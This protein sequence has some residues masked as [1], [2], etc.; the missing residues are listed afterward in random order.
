MLYIQLLER[1]SIVAMTAYVFSRTTMF[2]NFYHDKLSHYNKVIMILFFAALSILGDYLGIDVGNR[3]LA[4]TRPIGAIVGGYLGGPLVGVIIGTIAG[5]HRYTLGGFTAL[6]CAVATVFEGLIGGIVGKY[7]KRAKQSFLPPML[8]G[9]AAEVC[10]MAIILLISRPLMDAIYLEKL[11]FLPMVIINTIGVVLFISMINSIKNEYDK[12]F[13]TESQKA[14]IIAQKTISYLKKG[15]NKNTAESIV[16]IIYEVSGID[17][18]C[19][20]DRHE[21][22]AYFGEKVDESNLNRAINEYIENSDCTVINNVNVVSDKNP[23]IFLMVPI[24][25]NNTE[26][27]GL[28]GFKFDSAKQIN[29]YFIEFTRDLSLLLSTQIELYK[30]NKLAQE[31]NVAKL[32]ALRTQIQPH[33]LFNAL[34]TISSFCRT[35]PLQARDLIIELA[36][37]FRITLKRE[38][39]FATIGEE[40]EFLNSYLAI[41]K[42]RFGV[43]IGVNIN[44]PEKVLN[45]L[46]PVFIIQPIIENSIKHGLLHKPE[47]GTVNLSAEVDDN[48]ISFTIEDTGIGMSEEKLERLITKWPGIGLRNVNKRLE[49]LF[50]EDAGLKIKSQP[51]IGTEVQFYIPADISRGEQI[52]A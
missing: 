29:D 25:I 41:E 19:I 14:L 28:I 7:F 32:K 3:A 15:Y 24:L 45:C 37:Y 12:I 4:N 13:A 8:A 6:A 49:L 5:A 39:D 51:G 11:I 31:A 34:S 23:A 40:I 26:L 36:N 47:G 17:G 2:K 35:N 33:F 1:M 9:L 48:R 43:R 16:K 22:L 30:L 38:D 18:V 10:Q 52:N 42:A 46:M 27:E 50:G 44:I 20:C 21:V